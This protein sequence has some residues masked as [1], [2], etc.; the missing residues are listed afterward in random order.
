LSEDAQKRPWDNANGVQI[1][2]QAQE[3]GMLEPLMAQLRKDYDR[4]GV[5]FPFQGKDVLELG[6]DDLFAGLKEHMYRLLMEYFDQYLNLMYAVDIPERDFSTLQLTDAVDAAGQLTVM[7]ITR[8][9]HKLQLRQR[10]GGADK[11]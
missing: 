6:V 10:F 5:L 11:S 4:A 2:L 9:W 3:S 1:L 7:V 8:E